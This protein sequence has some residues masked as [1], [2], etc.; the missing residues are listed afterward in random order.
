M[1][2]TNVVLG[3]LILNCSRHEKKRDKTLGTLMQVI[4]LFHSL[5]AV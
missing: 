3:V 1:A 5:T 2:F 4:S